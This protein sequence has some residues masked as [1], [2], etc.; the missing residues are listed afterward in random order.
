[1]RLPSEMVMERL[2]FL[3]TPFTFHFLPSPCLR[4][5]TLCH[6]LLAI[7]LGY[8]RSVMN[9]SRVRLIGLIVLVLGLA[10]A[11]GIY[12]FGER[13]AE[14]TGTQDSE[15]LANSIQL[16]N[17]RKADREIEMGFGKVY[18]MVIHAE[19][20]WAALPVYKKVAFSIAAATIVASVLCFVLAPQLRQ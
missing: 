4:L 20:W 2:G 6:W 10:S 3:N 13:A 15:E 11:E 17:Q 1:M 14:R 7:N 16:E 18:V 5:F 19:E 12:W 8:T 9:R